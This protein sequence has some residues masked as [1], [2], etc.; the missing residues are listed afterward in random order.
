MFCK[1]T[2]FLL[3]SEHY[4]QYPINIRIKPLIDFLNDNFKMLKNQLFGK[5]F[6]N[7]VKVLWNS[8][9]Q[10]SLKNILIKFSLQLKKRLFKKKNSSQFF[11][12]EYYKKINSLKLN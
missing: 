5:I 3:A 1:H 7:F 8:F 6:L 9:Y 2:I 10:V 11:S 4:S 12:L